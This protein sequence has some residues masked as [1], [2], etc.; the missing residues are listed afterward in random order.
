MRKA[1]DIVYIFTRLQ[2]CL[3]FTIFSSL[4]PFSSVGHMVVSRMLFTSLVFNGQGTEWIHLQLADTWSFTSLS[5]LL[6]SF[7][8]RILQTD[9]PGHCQL[10]DEDTFPVVW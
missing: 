6:I 4:Q 1:Q 9:F 2:L 5:A 10:S 3:Y 8:S 7:F